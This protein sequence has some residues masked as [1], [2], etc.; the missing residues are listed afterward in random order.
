MR[1]KRLT[2]EELRALVAEKIPAGMVVAEHTESEHWY[3]HTPSGV[4]LPS[5]T[6]IAGLIQSPHLK[7]WAATVAIDYLEE[8]SHYIGE[9]GIPADLRKAAVLAH[10]GVFE[11]AGDIG[12]QGHDVIERYLRAW[13]SSGERPGAPIDT[14]ITGEDHRLWAISGSAMKFMDK[15]Q[16]IPI[17]TEMKIAYVP[18][19]NPQSGYGGTLDALMYLAFP[20]KEGQKPLPGTGEHVH[21]V[22]QIG[23]HWDR[24]E[25]ISCGAKWQYRFTLVDWKTSN[26]VNDKDEYVMQT[27]AYWKALKALIGIAPERIVIV[28]LD[29]AIAK[30][31]PLEVIKPAQAFTAFSHLKHVYDYAK[32]KRET[33][34][35]ALERKSLV[36]VDQL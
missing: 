35:L 23:S 12:T 22:M 2:P 8:R 29:K 4:L 1:K 24:L 15:Y 18:P 27:S 13:I 25:C 7:R 14:F 28:R 34:S 30:Y 5:V 26:S 31:E 9:D 21:E 10:E 6:T 17:A 20:E 36:S 19:K 33:K 16:A 3:R 32:Q 11:D